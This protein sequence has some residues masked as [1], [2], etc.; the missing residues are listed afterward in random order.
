MDLAVRGCSGRRRQHQHDRLPHAV[1]RICDRSGSPDELTVLSDGS[2]AP[3][4]A[5]SELGT[6]LLTAEGFMSL[7]IA[8]DEPFLH[9]LDVAGRNA[10]PFASQLRQTTARPASKHGGASGSI[11]K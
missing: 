8:A 7:F 4:T 2:S 3:W 1:S 11:G 6:V 5:A 10:I 9:S